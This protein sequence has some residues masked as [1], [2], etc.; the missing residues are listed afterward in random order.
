MNNNQSHTYLT[1]SV[2]LFIY[3]TRIKNFSDKYIRTL[4]QFQ[5]FSEAFVA[6]VDFIKIAACETV[7]PWFQV[8]RWRR[9]SRAF[10]G[11]LQC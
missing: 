8:V 4:T 11:H 10:D 9:F 2:C 3:E 5:I 7:R 6:G 1:P